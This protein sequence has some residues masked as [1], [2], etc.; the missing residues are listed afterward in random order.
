MTGVCATLPRS[1]DQRLLA[2]V[3]GTRMGRCLLLADAIGVLAAAC[4]PT[5]AQDEP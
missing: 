4:D 2:H 5:F 3:A 1:W